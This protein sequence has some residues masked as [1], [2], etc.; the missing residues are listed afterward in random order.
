MF[1]L[2]LILLLLL[3]F[4]IGLKRGLILQVLHL[5]SFI[6]AFIVAVNYYDKLGSQL[7]LWIPYP[8]LPDKSAWAEFLQ[9]LPL[10][11]GFYNA[12]AFAV[13]FF[14]V[15]IILQ[16]I[17][18]ML[19]FVAAIPIVNSV[20]KLLGSIF[21]FLEIYLILFILLYIMALTPIVTVQNWINHSSIALFIL[22][23]TP[24]FSDKIMELWFSYV[25][26]GNGP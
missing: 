1:S 9:M 6:I 5:V 14:A 7:A 8:D 16:I 12:V 25:D 17:A 10:E 21:G 24:Y 15:K 18:S 4:L 23:Q 20:N 13:I 2:I 11:N 19:D 26:N 3:G 22:E